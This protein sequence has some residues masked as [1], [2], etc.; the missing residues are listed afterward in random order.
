MTEQP[1]Q[2]LSIVAPAVQCILSGEKKTEIRSWAPPQL[3]L[4]DLV[5]VENTRYLR[6]DGE[7]DPDGFARAIVDITGVSPWTKEDAIAQG[8]EWRPGYLAWELANIRKIDPPIAAPAKR[9]IYT[10]NLRDRL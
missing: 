2:A 9:R 4:H 10:L 5:L 1:Y 7:E 6:K 3:P 8:S